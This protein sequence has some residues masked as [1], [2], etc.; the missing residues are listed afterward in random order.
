M[1]MTIEHFDS[2]A[3]RIRFNHTFLIDKK[4]P[5]DVV[6][7]VTRIELQNNFMYEETLFF[8]N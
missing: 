5:N 7:L 2:T 1:P 8:M 3:N 4:L 6:F